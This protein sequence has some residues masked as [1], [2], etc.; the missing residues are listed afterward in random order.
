MENLSHKEMPPP[1]RGGG[2]SFLVYSPY[3]QKTQ[4]ERKQNRIL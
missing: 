3:L 1:P 2:F 4:N